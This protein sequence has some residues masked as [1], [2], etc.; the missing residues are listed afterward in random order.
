MPGGRGPREKE[1]TNSVR[2]AL[3]RP[4]VSMKRARMNPEPMFSPIVMKRN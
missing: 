2:R 3:E 1:K 4:V